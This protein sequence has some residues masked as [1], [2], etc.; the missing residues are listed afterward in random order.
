MVNNYLKKVESL[1][2]KTR[3]YHSRNEWLNESDVNSVNN[4][5]EETS[6][7]I[8]SQYDQQLKAPLY[9]DPFLVESVLKWK[10]Q[11]VLAKFN[12]L[13][14]IKKPV[15]KNETEATNSTNTEEEVKIDGEQ[16]KEEGE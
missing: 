8:N 14:T 16:K 5:I 12:K 15:V 11:D 9:E 7:Y 4:M 1:A 3:E 10:Y 13:K 6:N 2:I